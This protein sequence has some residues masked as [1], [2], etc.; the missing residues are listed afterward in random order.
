MV[1]FAQ[2]L[3]SLTLHVFDL[4]IIITGLGVHDMVNPLNKHKMTRSGIFHQ[5]ILD[6]LNANNSL[7]YFC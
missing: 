2:L 5:S 6:S 1:E 3:H 4:R 7:A